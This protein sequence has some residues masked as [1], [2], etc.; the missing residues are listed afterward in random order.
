MQPVLPLVEKLFPYAYSIVAS[1]NDEAVSAYLEELPFDVLEYASGSEIN[2]WLIPEAHVVERATIRKD[3]TL[4]YDGTCSPLGVI[5]QSQSF[6]G[7]LALEELLLHLHVDPMNPSAV[8]YHWRQ[9]YGRGPV[10]WGF[11]LPS[12]LRDDLVEG[13]YDIDLSTRFVPG[14][15]K[16]FVTTLP[17]Q[18]DRTVLLNAH[19][20]HPYQA[21][22]DISGV[23]V[24]IRAMHAIA[25]IPNRRLT[26][27]LMIAPEL[28]G[29]M[30]WL[31][32]ESAEKTPIIGA[33][34]LKSVGNDSTLRMQESFSGNSAMD[35]A[36]HAVMLKRFGMFN[37]G[38]FRT[39]YGNDEIVFEAPG[40]EIPTIEFTRSPFA[41]Y[42]SDADRPEKLNEAAL[43][44]TLNVILDV[45]RHLENDKFYCRTSNGIPCLSNP[46]FDLYFPVTDRRLGSDESRELRRRWN[47]LM[48]CLPRYLDGHIS[49]AQI[50]RHHRL[51]TD[52][53]TAYIERWV[54]KGLAELMH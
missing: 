34:L 25:E 35:A 7:P 15:M 53:V 32:D 46:K 11:C 54:E 52:E 48:N 31:A 3:G 22:D 29:P 24:G 5:A 19:N 17:G 40:A 10:D 4:I 41:E 37:G 2:G 51:P 13:V 50:A 42:H 21:N 30:F 33:L 49:V 44:E 9:L 28:L 36:G 18:S 14:T 45:V 6:T 8:P 43:Q 20:C 12:S 27:A 39:V 47:L 23:A 16:V 1:G 26:Y 38:P